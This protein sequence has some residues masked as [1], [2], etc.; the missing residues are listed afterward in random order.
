MNS[1]ERFFAA[2]NHEPTDR[3]PMDLLIEPWMRQPLLNYLGVDSY[4]A[5]LSKLDTDIRQLNYKIFVKGAMRTEPGAYTDFWGVRRI[6]VTNQFGS[7]DEPEIMPFADMTEMSQVEAYPWPTQDVV[8]F[9]NLKPL[10]EKYHNDYAVVF[11]GPGI[12]D[13]INGTAFARGTEQV[14]ID[15]GLE[16]PVGLALMEKRQEFFE[17]FTQR[18]LEQAGGL[19]DVLWIGD[20]YGTQI[21]PLMS[22]DKWKRLF[23]P[24]MQAFID[25]GHKYGAKVMLHSCGS[26]RHLISTWIDMGLDIYQA[27]QVE[28]ANMDPTE[29]FREFGNNITFHGM[30]GLQSV[31]PHGTVDEVKAEV[32]KRIV[33]SGGSG[34]I[35]APAHNVQPDVPM[36]NLMALYEA[37]REYFE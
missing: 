26:N 18:A 10:C 33:Q 22:I 32:R 17:E 14:I 2:V 28:A 35:L 27:V 19:I 23:G 8:D 25:I 6:P 21:G 4:D 3:P 36:E 15:I 20:D 24:K 11:G 12:M 1:R 7:Y 30:I 31:L 9:S 13:L 5:V 16:D 29:L 34:Y 37:G